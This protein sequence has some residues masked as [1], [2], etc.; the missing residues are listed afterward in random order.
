VFKGPVS[1]SLP[2]EDQDGRELRTLYAAQ[3][4]TVKLNTVY[5]TPYREKWEAI[6]IE[7]CRRFAAGQPLLNLV[8]KEKWF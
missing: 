3:N 8:D 1:R 5:G 4:V 7:N 6:L 2:I